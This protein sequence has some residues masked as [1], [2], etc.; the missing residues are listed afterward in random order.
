MKH[1]I[2]NTFFQVSVALSLLIVTAT[3][4]IA[5]TSDFDALFFVDEAKRADQRAAF[6]RAER[7]VWSMDNEDLIAV[8]NDLDDYPLAPYLIAKKLGHRMSLRDEDAIREFLRQ[9]DNTVLARDLRR[10]WLQ[11]LAK[12]DQKQLF[13]EFYDYPNNASLQC[14]FLEYRYALGLAQEEVFAQLPALWNV[15]KSQAK[16][17]DP[18]FKKWMQAGLLSE[19]LILHRIEKSADGGQHTL[20][21][22]LRT[23]LPSDKQYLAD[24]WAEVRRN[25]A[26]VRH[27]VRYSGKYPNIEADIISYALARLIWR[28]RDLA[29]S[30]YER[31]K[32]KVV[33]SDA[34]RARIIHRFAVALALDEHPQAENWLIQASQVEPE[35]ET[36]RWHLAYLLK[37][38]DWQR[39]ALLIEKSPPQ[40][41]NENQFQYWLAR[42]YEK[43]GR[44][45]QALPLYR[46]LAT[47]RHYYGFLASARLGIPHSLHNAPVQASHDALRKIINLPATQ[48]AYELRALGRYY[49]ARLEWNHAQR[50]LDDNEKVLAAVVSSAWEWHD[51]S[52]FTLSREGYLDDVDRRFPTAFAELL[53]RE[54]QKNNIPPEWAFAI[55]RRE[56]SFMTDAISSADARGL[57]QILPSTARYL[58]SR[59][60]SAKDLLDADV[61]ARIGNKYLRYLLNKLDDNALLATASYNA[62]WRKV[63]EWLPQ[64]GAVPADIWVETIPY[65]ET[66]NYVKA[67][68]AYQQ[69]YQDKLSEKP[70]EQTVF[71][72]FSTMELQAD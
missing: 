33:F 60:I 72:E 38:Q 45:E 40:L 31:A 46:Q 37:Q 71:A 21:P 50:Q 43:L 19:D 23:L 30:T 57:M 28:D 32:Q 35:S 41:T 62:G 52:I 14:T 29:L 7:R 15:G 12:R 1:P 24:R 9:Y 54:A 10:D 70:V 39:I 5:Q 25:P 36:M 69:I 34:Q 68:L 44:D 42:A 20:I 58:E 13:I 18:L 4:A 61:N 8:I 11:Y 22:Y 6:L 66:R 16:E 55:A 53:T 3:P 49:P 51:Q 63:S 26:N 65:R 2:F 64:S 48:R 17:C 27:L 67:V 59:R 47:E 56:S